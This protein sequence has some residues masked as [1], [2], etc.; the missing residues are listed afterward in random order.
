MGMDRGSLRESWLDELGP[1]LEASI[2]RRAARRRRHQGVIDLN[3]I[4]SILRRADLNLGRR[5]SPLRRGINI[6]REWSRA[7]S[8]LIFSDWLEYALR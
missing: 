8:S 1:V 6:E 3:G 4:D 5:F 2:L 7:T